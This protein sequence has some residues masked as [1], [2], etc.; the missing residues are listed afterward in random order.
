MFL[1]WL[2]PCLQFGIHNIDVAQSSFLSLFWTSP[3]SWP[4][5]ASFRVTA[6]CLYQPKVDF[7]FIWIRVGLTWIDTRDQMFAMESTFNVIAVNGKQRLL[8]REHKG[9]LS[10]GLRNHASSKNTH[11]FLKRWSLDSSW[12]QPLAVLTRILST[13]L[14]FF[15]FMTEER[16]DSSFCWE[17]LLC[18]LIL[19]KYHLYHIFVLCFCVQKTSK[20]QGVFSVIRQQW[21]AAPGDPW[22]SDE[23]SCLFT[24]MTPQPARPK[25]RLVHPAPKCFQ[26]RL[27]LRPSPMASTFWITPPGP[28]RRWLSFPRRPTSRVSSGPSRSKAKSP[29]PRGQT[30]SSFLAATTALRADLL[31]SLQLKAVAPRERVQSI[32]KWKLMLNLLLR[33]KHVSSFLIFEI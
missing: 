30:S 12:R 8:G 5:I 10:A 21:D 6:L 11:N 27:P 4:K 2:Q 9:L 16:F 31:I 26:R 3:P 32:S 22:S 7:H 24:K 28:T 33:A 19:M 15:V 17:L 25:A 14:H 18:M 20:H 23:G 13:I 1:H 29:E